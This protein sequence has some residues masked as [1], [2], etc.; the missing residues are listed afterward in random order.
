M[1]SPPVKLESK[2]LLHYSLITDTQTMTVS[3]RRLVHFNKTLLIEGILVYIMILF[4]QNNGHLL[5]TKF[6]FYFGLFPIS[7]L[8]DSISNQIVDKM[9]YGFPRWE[10]EYEL[11]SRALPADCS[12]CC[13][14]WDGRTALWAWTRHSERCLREVCSLKQSSDD[15]EWNIDITEISHVYTGLLHNK[16]KQRKTGDLRWSTR[17]SGALLCWTGQMWERT[18]PTIAK[19]K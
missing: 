5:K 3:S 4:D 17:R 14:G 15:E 11:G 9:K 10:P 19:F 18:I 16:I 8:S 1:M 13:W 7:I 12:G 6:H 2:Y